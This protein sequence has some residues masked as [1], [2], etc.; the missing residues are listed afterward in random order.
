MLIELMRRAVVI[1]VLT[2]EAVEQAVP[3]A[4]ALVRGGLGVL[5]VTLR[6][7]PALEAIRR[8]AGEVEGAVIGAGTVLSRADLDRAAGAGARFAVSPGLTPALLAPH[9]LPLLPGVATPSELMTGLEAGLTAFK[10]FPAMPMGGAAVL[11]AW[12]GPFPQARFCPTG[13]VDA[14]NAAS[15]LALPNVLCVGGAWVAP[16]ALVEAGRW[17]EITRLAEQAAALARCD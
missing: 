4:R 10:F 1:P 5:E 13:G 15:L 6:T 11:K 12:G 7:E 9:A 3:L 2:V 17:D 8:M 16:R 14:A